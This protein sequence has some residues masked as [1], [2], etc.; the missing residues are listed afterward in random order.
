MLKNL[1]QHTTWTAFALLAFVS[2]GYIAWRH[3]PLAGAWIVALGLSAAALVAAVALRPAAPAPADPPGAR[4]PHAALWKIIA[5]G[6]ALRVLWSCFVPAEQVSDMEHYTRIARDLVRTGEFITPGPLPG[7]TLR[8]FRSPGYPALLAT[9]YATVGEH[10][11]TYIVLNLACFVLGALLTFRIGHALAGDR[12]GLGAALLLALWPGH[13]LLTG[14]AL[15]E[16]VSLPLYAAS[17]L[18]W[19]RASERG[20]AWSVALGLLAGASAMV[21]PSLVLLPAVWFACCPLEPRRWRGLVARAALATVCM[22]AMILPWTYRN[23]RVLGEPVLISTNGGT[24]LYRAN[25]PNA[26]GSFLVAGERDLDSW[27]EKDEAEWNRT[28]SAWAKEWIV[29]NPVAFLKLA[30]RKQG[31]LLGEDTFG[32]YY[33]LQRVH[34]IEG[35]R[36]LTVAAA[37]NLWWFLFWCLVAAGTL[38]GRH[39]LRS[40]PFGTALLLMILMQVTVHSVY[41]SQSRH[42]TPFMPLLA[43]LAAMAIVPRPSPADPERAT[44]SGH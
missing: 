26:T 12:A 35:G 44:R 15:T 19:R 29:G 22:F 2:F 25:N 13:I 33:A 17:L 21:R 27:A 20:L 5:I 39:L 10:P 30:L 9:L 43:V 11:A 18:C 4:R 23:Q 14:F 6:V 31:L 37:T 38:R 1:V 42:H 3:L 34:D 28:G 32:A 40:S 7:Q 8:A 16:L 24:V 36:Y 41:E